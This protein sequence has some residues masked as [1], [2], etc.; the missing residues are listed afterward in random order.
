MIYLTEQE[1]F[2]NQAKHDL[3]IRMPRLVRAITDVVINNGAKLHFYEIGDLVVRPTGV[4]DTAWEKIA[5]YGHINPTPGTAMHQ[6][7][8]LGVVCSN[9][10]KL[11]PSEKYS[12]ASIMVAGGIN[13]KNRA[14]KNANNADI[15]SMYQPLLNDGMVLSGIYFYSVYQ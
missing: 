7:W 3:I 12:L 9:I 2:D 5:P 15:Y 4:L 10:P 13:W 1:M 8:Q 6:G 14:A 11:E